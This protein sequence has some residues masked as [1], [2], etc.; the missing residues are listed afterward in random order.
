MDIDL[1]RDCAFPPLARPPKVGTMSARH[2]PLNHTAHPQQAALRI[3]LL[4]L[5]LL[6]PASALLAQDYGSSRFLSRGIN[7]RLKA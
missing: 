2:H 6:F 4:I 7:R 3:F 5:L 1:N